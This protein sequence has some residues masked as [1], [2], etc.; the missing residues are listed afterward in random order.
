MFHYHLQILWS[1]IREDDDAL[2]LSLVSADVTGC[3]GFW[4]VK[5]A[6]VVSFVQEGNKPVLGI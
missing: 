6:K 1:P 5:E 2:N 3:I 4:N